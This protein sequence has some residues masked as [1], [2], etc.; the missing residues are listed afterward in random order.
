[1]P[2]L[3]QYVFAYVVHEPVDYSA[4]HQWFDVQIIGFFNGASHIIKLCSH[5]VRDFLNNANITHLFTMET[6]FIRNGENMRKEI[7]N[8]LTFL[9]MKGL[10]VLAQSL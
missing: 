5:G 9:H 7:R 6:H 1:M 3:P 10:K 4:I 2:A 8:I